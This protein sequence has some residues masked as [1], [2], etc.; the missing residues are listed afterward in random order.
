MHTRPA[1]KALLPYMSGI[2]LARWL[3]APAPLLLGFTLLPLFVGF[4]AWY[5]Q[6]TN[7]SLVDLCLIGALILLGTV[8][9]EFSTGY[10][11]RNHIV[12]FTQISEPVAL[13]GIVVKYPQARMDHYQL[14]VEGRELFVKGRVTRVAGKALVTVPGDTCAAA[15]GDEIVVRGRLRRPPDAR[16]PG[17]FDYRAYLAAQ[18]VFAALYASQDALRVVSTE[19]GNSFFR[20][21]VM[22]AKRYLDRYIGEQL[23]TRESALLSALILGERG[24]IPS[25]F[26][27]DMAKLGIIHVLAVSGLHVGFVMAISLGVLGLLR[28][29]RVAQIVLTLLVLGFY[30]CLTNLKPPVVRASIMGAVLLLGTLVQRR[31]DAFNSLA[32]AALIILMANPLQLFQSGFQLSFAAVG[33]ILYLYPKLSEWQPFKGALDVSRHRPWLRYSVSLMLVSAAVFL[34]TLPFTLLYFNRLPNFSVLANLVIVPLAFCGLASGVTAAVVNLALPGLADVFMNATWVFLSLLT[35]FVDW[36]AGLPFSHW[37]IH[38][39]SLWTAGA[40]F[41]GLFLVINIRQRRARYLLVVGALLLGNVLIWRQALGRDIHLRV[42]FF[43]VGQGDA[44]LVRFPGGRH[45]LIDG[46]RRV[47]EYDAGAR[48]IA[49]YLRREGIRRLDAVVLSHADADHVGGLPHILRSFEVQ[50]VWDNGQGRESRTYAEYLHVIDSLKIAR[51]RVQAGDLLVEFNPAKVF[52]MHPTAEYLRTNPDLNDASLV[53]KI[54]YG[55]VDLLFPGDVER[56][57]EKQLVRYA[58]LLESEILKVPHHGSRT[59]S[60]SP[61]LEPVQPRLAVLSVGEHNK[62]GHPHAD[63]LRRLQSATGQILRTDRQA[64]VILQTDGRE[65]KRIRWK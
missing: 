13:S 14:T 34:G 15:Y 18:G 29:P 60:T 52:A 49:P 64:A 42:I 35:R 44:A 32:L 50:E 61:L 25:E 59:S 27:G 10:F 37:E 62:F 19:H 6:P 2:L 21:L 46:G 51:R 55:D 7:R 48:V 16:N 30:A 31:S 36:A 24:E 58:G 65:I 47:L 41:A 26:R 8:R 63:A 54:S 28:I 5:H 45:M 4:T 23:P 39:Y 43:D 38:K 53:L 3:N 17:E 57:G 12:N 56:A 33:A 40:Y 9:T 1:L 22:P 11:S 20:H